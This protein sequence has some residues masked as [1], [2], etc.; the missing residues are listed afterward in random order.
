MTGK[1]LILEMGTGNDLHGG[2]YTKAATRAVQDAMHHSYLPLFKT[3]DLDR[4]KMIVNVTIGVQEPDKVD[5][6]TVR[7]QFPYGVVSVTVVKGGLNVPDE[8]GVNSVV[9]ASAGVE[10]RFDIA[11]GQFQLT[12]G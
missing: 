8:D 9:V 12:G 10:A 2:D 1:R 5:V 4:D 6:E 7:Q 11:D 3:L